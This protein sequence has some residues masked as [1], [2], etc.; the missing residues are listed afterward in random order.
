MPAFRKTV[1][2]VVSFLVVLTALSA[3]SAPAAPQPGANCTVDITYGSGFRYPPSYAVWVQD[4]AAGETAT[5]YVTGKASDDGSVGIEKRPSA[6]PVWFG[7]KQKEFPGQ[8]K[9]PDTLSGATPAKEA[10]LE[11][12]VP[13]KFKGKKL[14]FF[15]EANVSYDYND[16]YR[17]GLKQ[18]EEGYND[19][20]GQPSIIWSRVFEPDPEGYAKSFSLFPA[21]YGDV[22]GLDHD[23]SKDDTHITTADSIFDDIRIEYTYAP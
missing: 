4:V 20:N 9:L 5:L 23:I 15:V 3:C 14:Q 13:D 11:V 10:H 22:L 6:L 12:A 21:G 16:Y 7:V 19:V 8:K 17:E 2:I 18:G 1:L